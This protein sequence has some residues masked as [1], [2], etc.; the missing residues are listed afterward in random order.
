MITPI[1]YILL[2]LFSLKILWNLALPYKMALMLLRCAGQ[3]TSRVTFMTFVEIGFLLL[4][5][6]AAALSDGGNC[7]HS[8][9]NIAL[10][11][12]LAIVASYVHLIVAGMIAGWVVSLLRKGQK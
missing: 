10:W 11:G 7:F 2:G 6:G 9:R 4:S 1:L 5:I 8:P 12:A 3:K